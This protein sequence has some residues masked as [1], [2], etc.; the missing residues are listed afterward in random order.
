MKKII[1]LFLFVFAICPL[2][3]TTA[4]AHSGGT[5]S[6]GGH[7]NGDEY[8]YH[9]GY[10]A[11]DHYDMDGDGDI[12][13]PYDFK[14]NV[15]H[16]R[17]DTADDT[18]P[19]PPANEEASNARETGEKT[20]IVIIVLEILIGAVLLLCFAPTVIGVVLHVLLYVLVGIWNFMRYMGSQIKNLFSKKS[21]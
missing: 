15:D 17:K 1:C 21:K 14:D 2:L 10:P 6:N 8:H 11:H 7:Y 19:T 13:C 9:H 20:N 4:K 18:A 5:D 3:L 12:D 16:D